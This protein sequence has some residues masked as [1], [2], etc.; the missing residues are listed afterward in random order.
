MPGG[1]QQDE[2]AVPE[3]VVA[4]LE[5]GK[6]GVVGGFCSDPVPAQAGQV[7]VAAHQP[8]HLGQRS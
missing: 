1:E 2:A 4:G 6:A 5:R 8:A 7:N 3:Q